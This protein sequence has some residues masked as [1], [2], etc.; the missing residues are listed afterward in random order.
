MFAIYL[1]ENLLMLKESLIFV[2]NKAS[3]NAINRFDKFQIASELRSEFYKKKLEF[4]D[5]NSILYLDTFFNQNF[6]PILIDFFYIIYDLVIENNAK[7]SFESL[8]LFQFKLFNHSCPGRDSN[9]FKKPFESFQK[10]SLKEFVF[11][12]AKYVVCDKSNKYFF[13][14]NLDR[15]LSI[16]NDYAFTIIS[17][18]ALLCYSAR[19][20][21]DNFHCWASITQIFTDILEDKVIY[22]R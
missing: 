16:V 6:Q 5:K 11:D 8:R 15:F 21:P 12:C 3:E 1:E 20:A 13:Q 22:T 17:K 2:I 9:R 19:K 18:L 7:K 4:P 10:Q 14:Q